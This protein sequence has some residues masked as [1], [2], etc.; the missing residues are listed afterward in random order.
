M[1][2]KKIDAVISGRVQGVGFR[3]YVLAKAEMLGITGW[4]ANLPGGE[5]KTVAVGDETQISDFL[6]YLKKGPSGAWIEN[7]DYKI[8][9]TDNIEFRGFDIKYW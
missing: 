8:E 2:L 7:I 3:Y 5:V 4:V 9:N 6:L 1:S